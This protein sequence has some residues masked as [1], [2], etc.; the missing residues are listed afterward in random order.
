VTYYTTLISTAELDEHLDDPDWV[1]MDCRFNLQ[2]PAYG[3]Q[4]YAAVHIASALFADLNE[5]LSSPVLPGKTGRHPLPSVE[6]AAQKFS[7]WGIDSGVQV[8]AYDDQGGAL[9]AARLWWLLR[10]LGHERAAVLDG[11]WQHWQQESRRVRSGIESR[12]PRVFVPHERPELVIGADEVLREF[13]D[14]SF[15]LFDVRTLERYRGEREPIDPVAGR[16]PGAVSAP[17]Q[18]NL[19][20]EGT[21]KPVDELKRQ[22]RALLADLPAGR[23]AFY[24]GSGGTAQH[25]ILALLHAGLGEARLYAGSWSEWITDPERPVTRG[26]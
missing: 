18:E 25:S 22:Y 5:D 11:G 24:C 26:E 19:T 23:T 14:T 15:R 21:F 8:V 7:A 13:G 4:A 17:Y 1:I 6:F 16:I 3:R 10:W 12:P 2:E 20:P 9:A